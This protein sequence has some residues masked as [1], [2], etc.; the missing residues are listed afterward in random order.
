MTSEPLIVGPQS[1][2][3]YF[4]DGLRSL[5]CILGDSDL[6]T[7]P[8]RPNGTPMLLKQSFFERLLKGKMALSSFH[9]QDVSAAQ[10]DVR[11]LNLT[12]LL[13]ISCSQLDV[14]TGSSPSFAALTA[15]LGAVD[16]ALQEKLASRLTSSVQVPADCTAELVRTVVLIYGVR[17]DME[18]DAC[19]CWLVRSGSAQ[20][21]LHLPSCELRPLEAKAGSAFVHSRLSRASSAVPKAQRTLHW[22]VKLCDNPAEFKET[23]FSKLPVTP[24]TP[25]S[26]AGAG[27]FRVALSSTPK[28][29]VPAALSDDE[30]ESTWATDSEDE[31]KP[32]SRP[33]VVA[34]GFLGVEEAATSTTTKFRGSDQ[35]PKQQMYHRTNFKTEEQTWGPP[36]TVNSDVQRLELEL[37]AALH[38]LTETK[39]QLA[40]MQRQESNRSSRSRS[41][42]CS[43]VVVSSDTNIQTTTRPRTHRGRPL[44]NAATITVMVGLA[45]ATLM[46]LSRYGLK[47]QKLQRISPSTFAWQIAPLR[48]NQH[49]QL[50]SERIQS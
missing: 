31:V 16:A 9:M 48:R 8:T 14:S 28:R 41:S 17:R 24:R 43:N 3:R 49:S 10:V 47:S 27:Q 35:P 20:G 2:E 36:C 25:K 33:R 45:A 7:F 32:G 21:L 39:R 34:A 1:E 50:H 23:A 15:F 30:T 22:E 11:K 4:K 6:L 18:E 42:M 19:A 26:P 12:Q 44:L 37:K 5:R 46:S 38:E 40:E 13:F 29:P